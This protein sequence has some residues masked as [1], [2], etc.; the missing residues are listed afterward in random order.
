MFGLI[1][2]IIV[3]ATMVAGQV[4]VSEPVPEVIPVDTQVVVQ[5]EYIAPEPIEVVKMTDSAGVVANVPL[6]DET[7]TP[8]DS[9]ALFWSLNPD[10]LEMVNN[11]SAPISTPLT[12]PQ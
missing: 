1:K 3:I 11:N 10:I 4:S 2:L 5:A 12:N 7:V 9:W 8:E 6:T